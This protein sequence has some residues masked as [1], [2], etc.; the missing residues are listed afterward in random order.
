MNWKDQAAK[1]AEETMPKESWGLLAIIKGE[2]TYWPCKNIAES[3]FEY[4][5][6]DP[7]D[8]AECEDTGEIIGVLAHEPIVNQEPK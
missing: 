4:F 1:H 7:D 3:S 8:W 2:K 6:I 5:V